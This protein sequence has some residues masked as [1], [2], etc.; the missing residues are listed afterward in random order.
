M[1]K[2]KEKGT[3][4]KVYTNETYDV[5]KD[6]GVY[7]KYN[8]KQIKGDNIY[9]ASLGNK[10]NSII[11]NQTCLAPSKW[12]TN[13][14]QCQRVI[15]DVN[16]CKQMDGDADNIGCKLIQ[17]DKSKSAVVGVHQPIKLYLCK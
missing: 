10:I 1:I 14:E 8:R 11:P 2:K 17:P 15:S 9:S 16:Y 12:I 6:N 4:T 13:K 7:N 5:K 3:I